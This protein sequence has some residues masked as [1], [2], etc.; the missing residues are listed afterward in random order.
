MVDVARLEGLGRAIM[1]SSVE[2]E[3]LGMSQVVVYLDGAFADVVRVVADERERVARAERA[4]G[5]GS[6]EEGASGS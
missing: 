1:A 5:S 4:S 2:A 6:V 3:Y